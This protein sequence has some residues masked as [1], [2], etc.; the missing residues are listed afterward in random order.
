MV[1]RVINR[2]ISAPGPISTLTGVDFKVGQPVKKFSG[3]A[4]WFGWIVSAYKT[5][6]GKQRYVV[7]IWPQGFQMIAV[8]SNLQT[9][10]EEQFCYEGG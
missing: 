3:E 4:I 7:E 2:P 5:R 9:A 6:R 1:E 8:G 10:T